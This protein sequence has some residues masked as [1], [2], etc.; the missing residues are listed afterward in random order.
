[1]QIEIDGVDLTTV[2][3]GWYRSR[4]GVVSQD[5]RLF[6]MTIRENI[7][8]GLPQ[9]RTYSHGDGEPSVRQLLVSRCAA[10]STRCWQLG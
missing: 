4:I 10:S 9:A 7:A 6:G 1:M 8:Y 5:P 3:A 2:D